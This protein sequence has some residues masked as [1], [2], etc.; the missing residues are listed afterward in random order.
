MFIRRNPGSGYT[1]HASDQE[2]NTWNFAVMAYLDKVNHDL[3]SKYDGASNWSEEDEN[4][5]TEL[6]DRLLA[7]YRLI[8]V[9][10]MTAQEWTPKCDG[11][12]CKE[13][14]ASV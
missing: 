5:L 12:N 10:V 9:S 8:R 4:F 11:L 7:Q 1:V 3:H 6:Y 14:N 2:M 13:G